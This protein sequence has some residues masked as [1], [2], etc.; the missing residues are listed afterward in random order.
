LAWISDE[1]QKEKMKDKMT[2]A[3]DSYNQETTKT[4]KQ[5]LRQKTA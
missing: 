4:R 2:E 1:N 5:R 3:I